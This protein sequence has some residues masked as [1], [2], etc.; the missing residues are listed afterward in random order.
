MD[1]YS[2]FE[3]STT[4]L[5]LCNKLFKFFKAVYDAPEEVREYL[6]V[7]ESIR[8]VFQDVQDYASM[9]LKSSFSSEDGLQLLAVQQ[10]LK[11][12]ELEFALQPSL[13]EKLD[14]STAKSFFSK[15]TRRT[16]W[17]LRKETVEELTRKLEKVQS[18]LILAVSTS[19]G[20][21]LK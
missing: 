12:S 15:S 7:L 17:V 20:Y 14:P 11:D 21:V 8:L 1:A 10:V 16:E 6:V 5:T 13:V 18:L 3:A 9:H 2:I 4:V 19:T